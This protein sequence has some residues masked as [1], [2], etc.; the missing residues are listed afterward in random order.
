MKKIFLLTIISILICVSFYLN[1]YEYLNL[2]YIKENQDRLLEFYNQNFLKTI[3]LYFIIYILVASASLPGGTILTLIG[4]SLFG[5]NKGL[6]IISFASS[7]GATL[8][9]LI[10]RTILRDLIQSK[11]KDR[12]EVF[13]K[14]IEKEGLFYLFTLRLVPVVPFFII[15]M[16]MGLTKLKTLPF[17]IVSQIGML[18]GTAIY[19]NAGVQLSKVE[20]VS[21]ILSPAIILSL[22]LLGIFP[23]AVKRIIHSY[24]LR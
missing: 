18:A 5:F 12:L 22:S 10:S 3:F 6:L 11:F 21:D 7:I 17:Y 4:G 24:K 19:V 14:G 23:L 8:A 1:L 20:S 2:A 16:V 15:N 13:N 9:F